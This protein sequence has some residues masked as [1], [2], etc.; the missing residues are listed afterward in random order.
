MLE[1]SI[2]N[3]NKNLGFKK[4]FDGF[5]LDVSSGE[6]IGLIGDN[7]C[8]K[9]TLF[10]MIM[11]IEMLDSG[12]ISIRKNAKIGYLS[13]MP[14]TDMIK[15]NVRDYLR[16]QFSEILALEEEMK[17]LELQMANCDESEM[18]KILNRYG[19]IQQKFIDF[20]GYLIESKIDEI[21]N[22]FNISSELLSHD[23]STLSGGEKTVINL[24]AIMLNNPDILLLDEP[25]NNL[26]I[27]TLEWLEN[28]LVTYKGTII[29]SSHDRYFLDKVASK[30][31][32]I[33][34]GK[35]EIFNGNYSYY[36]QENERRILSEFEQYK[37]QQK[38][39]DA[40]K[41]KIKQ[42]QEFGRLAA[43][44]GESFF[45]RAASI[46]KR[47]DKLE[48]ILKPEEKK[49]LP[50]NFQMNNRSGKQVLIID[51]LSLNV[52]DRNLLENLKLNIFYQDR[53]CLMGKNGTGKSTLIKYI[54]ERYNQ[55]KFQDD[56]MK[57]GSN[58][59]IGYIPQIIEFEDNNATILE[60]ARK[61]FNGTE[62][63]LRSALAK[64]MFNGNNVFKRVGDLSGG[65][66]V[67]L[68]LFELMQSSV[69]FLI[70]DEPTNHIDIT[71]KEVLESALKE[72]Q[73]TILF[74]SHDRYFINELA[75]KVLYIENR[76][77]KEYLGNYDDY[78]EKQ[79]KVEAISI[80][81]YNKIKKNY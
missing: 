77:V 26:D 45:K 24:A 71:T 62:T 38:M 11:K 49:E 46:Q 61:Y 58:V 44:S 52:E 34:R 27:G 18:E 72:F 40:M 8:G 4:I 12:L 73:G 14:F 41:R 35:S 74:I 54:I 23:I 66:K 3:L 80:N 15:T 65:E 55:E 42:L 9:S 10:K 56:V 32:L 79:Q 13:Q 19:I 7:G 76:K 63:Y 78:K 67:R 37:D 28:Y 25:T 5:N 48:L 57:I 2:S 30:I 36:L 70:M 51:G 81:N 39:I 31:V 43:P 6:C 33:E 69:N 22:K 50:L 21:C 53:V 68:K 60:V 1:I 20:D 64:F 29:M 75:K 47:L 16:G 59:A 17:K